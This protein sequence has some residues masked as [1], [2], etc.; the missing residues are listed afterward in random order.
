MSNITKNSRRHYSSSFPSREVCRREARYQR[1]PS[2]ERYRG[3][4]VYHQRQSES[5]CMGTRCKWMETR[6]LALSFAPKCCWCSYARSLRF[7]VCS[8][9]VRHL[10][11]LNH[12]QDDIHWR[13]PCLHV[14]RTVTYSSIE[15]TFINRRFSGFK[16]AEMEVGAY[17]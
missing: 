2:K 9:L 13:R 8:L 3:H 15:Y 4:C 1:D 16:F 12:I 10:S 5:E 17:L 7:Y 14:S 6:T 11:I